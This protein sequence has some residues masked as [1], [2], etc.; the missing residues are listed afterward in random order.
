MLN[1]FKKLMA[2][3][4]VYFRAFSLDDAA[5]SH[6][7]RIDDEVIDTLVGR[8]YFV[9]PDY[10][11][12]WVNDAIF[13]PGNSVKLAVCLKESH[14]H[15]G[16]VYLDNVDSF[17]QNA[18]FGLMIGDKTQWGN[19][20]GTEMTLLMLYHAF[21]EMNLKRVYS[22]QLEDNIG[23]IKVHHKCGFQQE[24]ILRKAVFKHGELVNLNVMGILKEEFDAKV[25]ELVNG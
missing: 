11:K 15:I 14:Q 10:E 4:R 23:S 2:G 13:S 20:I 21:Y 8:K 5:T 1:E 17:N 25:S 12:K 24:G 18:M 19:G 9:S 22:Y 6:A 16:N 7:W 3:F